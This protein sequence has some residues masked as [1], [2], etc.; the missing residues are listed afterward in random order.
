MTDEATESTTIDDTTITGDPTEP[1]VP[2]GDYSA[3]RDAAKKAAEEW[4]AANPKADPD[5]EDDATEAAPE[6]TAKPSG[7]A[8]EAAKADAPAAA[9]DPNEPRVLK[10]LRARDKAQ[11]TLGEA[12]ARAQ[13]LEA[14]ARE[15]I[16]AFE[17][18]ALDRVRRAQEEAEAKA[19]A[20]L[21]ALTSPEE[22]LARQADAK[23]P[24]HQMAKR[25]E[26]TI[27]E[28]DKALKALQE[29]LQLLRRDRDQ[30]RQ[31]AFE[32]QR[33]VAERAF[34]AKA[35]EDQFPYARARWDDAELVQKGH[36]VVRELQEAARL[37]GE[38]FSCTDEEI[39]LVLEERAK[40][41]L[42]SRVGKLAAA[43]QKAGGAQAPQAAGP[44]KNGAR[45]PRTL[46]A[47]ASS[48]RRASPKPPSEMTEAEI[49]AEMR[50]AAK[51]AR[52]AATSS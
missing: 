43:P 40:S 46:S 23:D 45:P 26:S 39:L 5:D 13:R 17:R 25:F 27:A 24:L 20:T 10:L 21:E 31:T 48:E 3:L 36:E 52:R 16:A 38:P 22:I 6:A 33:T 28:R 19:R 47:S 32:R 29:E 51:A 15:R 35:A 8:A 1:A 12:E 11:Q 44:G 7:L 50:R 9:E 4:R 30:E 2:T 49:E 42:A 14:E 18:E 41:H 37:A 34:V